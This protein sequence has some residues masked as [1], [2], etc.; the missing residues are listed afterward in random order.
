MRAAAELCGEIAH[1]H[2][3]HGVAVLL[4]EERH[5]AEMLCL[6]IAHDLCLY[7]RALKHHVRHDGV[8][9]PYLIGRKSG[10]VRKVKAQMIRLHQ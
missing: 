1:L 4:A 7:V 9:L 8:D 6:V 10:E 5:C 2:N 3:T